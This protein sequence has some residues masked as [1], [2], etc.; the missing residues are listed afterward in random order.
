[1]LTSFNKYLDTD[2]QHYVITTVTKEKTGGKKTL[3]KSTN[4]V[5]SAYIALSL[6]RYNNM[7][8]RLVKT[9]VESC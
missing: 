2:S 6:T 8:H 9:V 5:F 3:L 7:S 4:L 1:M